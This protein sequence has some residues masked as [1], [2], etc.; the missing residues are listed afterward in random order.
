MN[1]LPTAKRA[2]IFSCLAEGNSMRATSR[3]CDVNM[4]AVVKLL[5]D[6]GQA[7]SAYQDKTFRNLK[8]RR[9]Q[10][11]EI[12]SFV[13]CKE[14]NATPEKKAKGQGDC[15]IWTAI[16]SETKLIPCW[17][18]GTRDGG[19]AWHFMHDLAGRLANRVQLTTDGHK[20]Y[21]AAVEDN[22]GT[23]IDYAMLNKIYGKPE[24]G[25]E[26]RYSPAQCMGA[27][28]AVIN[29]KPNFAHV[30][31]SHVERSNLT[32]RMSNRRFTRLTNAFSKK[33]ECHEHMMAISM[34]FYNFCRIHSSLRVTPAME[35]GVSD[36]IWEPS[37]VIAL[38][39]K[40]SD[41]LAA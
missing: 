39:D 11:D 22:F 15:W 6:L 20:A 29:G 7:C 8:C 35:A 2:Q 21:L 33:V 13:G 36:H 32:I 41:K 4:S 16:D 5:R 23:E 26:T 12:W 27:R 17:F 24:Q 1:Q 31:T 9:L 10:C 40:K 28:K 25:P 14:K 19:A 34:M 18:V 3:L 30:S 38:L 37:E